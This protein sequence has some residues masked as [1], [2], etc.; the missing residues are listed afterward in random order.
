MAKHIRYSVVVLAVA[1]L[2]LTACSGN[3]G[4]ERQVRGALLKAGHDGRPATGEEITLADAGVDTV[5]NPGRRELYLYILLENTLCPIND[6]EPKELNH[7]LI[8]FENRRDSL[9]TSIAYMCR[10]EHGSLCGGDIIKS[11]WNFKNAQLWC[12]DGYP[13]IRARILL[14]LARLYRNDMP[15]AHKAELLEEA[16]GLYAASGN[17]TGQ[18]LCYRELM[19][20]SDND[21]TAQAYADMAA[22]FISPDD[23]LMRIHT[24]AAYAMR[25]CNTL[26]GDSIVELTAPAYS[27]SPDANLAYYLALGHIK[28]DDM[29]KAEPYIRQ[30][31]EEESLHPLWHKL[32]YEKCM[33]EGD[34]RRAADEYVKY[35]TEDEMNFRHNAF[36][37]IESHEHAMAQRIYLRQDKRDRVRYTFI[38]MSVAI[39]ALLFAVTSIVIYYWLHRNNSI[40]RKENKKQEEAIDAAHRMV[41]E[42]E[43]AC[44]DAETRL[45]SLTEEK[46]RLLHDKLLT[47]DGKSDRHILD[48]IDAYTRGSAS[49]LMERHPKVKERDAVILF[50][51]HTGCRSIEISGLLKYKNTQ[52][53]HARLSR[54]KSELGLGEGETVDS[55]FASE[56]RSLDSRTAPADGRDNGTKGSPAV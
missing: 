39:V 55:W 14:S 48:V 2:L 42:K 44:H 35:D 47:L 28:S 54:L 5:K 21:S 26:G 37:N 52:S 17:S 8:Y 19:M 34:Y 36:V 24:G 15:T 30:V 22:S 33:R 53:L 18:S 56:F 11:V 31:K 49:L 9:Y 10:G 3:D 41:R 12:P 43:K 45:A 32:M 23:T 29:A 6:I 20:A 40:L 7:A 16:A 27:L 46:I 38:V 50:L 13:E 51:R 4:Y 25:F 1:S